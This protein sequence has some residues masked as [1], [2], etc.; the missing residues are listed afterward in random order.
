MSNQPCR[1]WFTPIQLSRESLFQMTLQQSSLRFDF[2]HS[3]LCESIRCA[4]A[5]SLRHLQPFVIGPQQQSFPSQ[6]AQPSS[7][8][9]QGISI[10]ALLWQLCRCQASS[11]S[12]FAHQN[13]HLGFFW[14]HVCIVDSQLQ[15]TLPQELTCGDTR[16]RSLTRT[17]NDRLHGLWHD[18]N[19]ALPVTASK[20]LVA[21]LAQLPLHHRQE[22]RSFLSVLRVHLGGVPD[23]RLLSTST[24]ISLGLTS[25]A[26]STLPSSASLSES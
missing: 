10:H 16:P 20:A 22:V 13:C 12:A 19:L 24:S 23:A 3:N 6:T 9:G 15:A 17:A 5:R 2:S 1:Q 11:T 26:R 7:K 4:L 8:E 25:T 21:L 14:S 18:P